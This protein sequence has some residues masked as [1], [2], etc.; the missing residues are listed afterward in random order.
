MKLWL[1][2]QAVNSNWDTYDSAVVVAKTED[3]AR[4]T[5][6][7]GEEHSS[8]RTWC[9]PKDVV[10]EYLGTTSRKFPNK[11]VCASFNGG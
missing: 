9:E 10:V 5:H 8:L 3:E 4:H 2:H 1:I 6:P 7:S 11:V